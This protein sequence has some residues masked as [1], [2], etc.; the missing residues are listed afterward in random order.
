MGV[1]YRQALLSG[2]YTM[3]GALTNDEDPR[4]DTQAICS[5]TAPSPCP[6][7]SP[8]ACNPAADLG[9]RSPDRL[10]HHRRRDRLV[11]GDHAR[12]GTPGSLIWM[13]L[14]NT[15]SIREGESY[16]TQPMA[17]GDFTWIMGVPAGPDRRRNVGGLGHP[18]APARLD[19]GLR[20]R[21]GPGS[22]LRRARRAAHLAEADWR[23]QW[24]LPGGI[25]A[26]TLG[27]PRPT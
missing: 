1:R 16:L 25:L 3:E 4:G 2:S 23:R 26:A 20:C 19:A 22:G 10:R 12:K 11:V 14:G 5:P 18:H 15:H 6:T 21:G 9:W 24:L 17:S 27:N 8:W 13:R 7:I